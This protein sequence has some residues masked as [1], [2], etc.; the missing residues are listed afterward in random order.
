MLLIDD[1]M[2]TSAI[3]RFADLVQHSSEFSAYRPQAQL[4]LERVEET[5]QAHES[6]FLFNRFPEIP[7][8]YYY[9][10]PDGARL[11]SGAVESN[12]SAAIATTCLLVDCVRGRTLHKDKAEAILA[13]FKRH[14]RVTRDGAFIWS[15]HLQKPHIGAI[16]SEIE[17]FSHAHIDLGFFVLTHKNGLN[18]STPEMPH[19]GLTLI[20]HIYL[21]DGE[22]TWS[23][24]GQELNRNRTYWPI[25]FDW[26]DL[27][28][29]NPRILEIAIEVYSEHYRKPKW[30]REFLGWA[31][32][33]RWNNRLQER[34][35]TPPSAPRLI[36]TFG[37]N[38]HKE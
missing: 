20:R 22:L 9:P 38:Q 25:A 12:M 7:G 37:S 6:S 18:L 1:A 23:V 14:A 13:Y 31:E 33:L 29:F 2:I 28:A 15:Y 36:R 30:A 24:D 17:D 10:S 16:K 35:F 32:I 11:Y 3:M 26:I 19:F 8:S 4:Y 27:T 34:D 5:V 21:G